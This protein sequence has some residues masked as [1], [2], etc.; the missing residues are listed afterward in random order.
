MKITPERIQADITRATELAA[1]AYQRGLE[2]LEIG[3][4]ALYNHYE[5]MADR[6]K[7]DIEFDQLILRAITK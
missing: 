7:F 2:A 1:A 6:A 5:Q 3:N 4:V